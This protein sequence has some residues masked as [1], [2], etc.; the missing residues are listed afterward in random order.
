VSQEGRPLFLQTVQDLPQRTLS[1]LSG[2]A[3]LW[4][5]ACRLASGAHARPLLIVVAER[6]AVAP[7]EAALRLYLTALGSGLPVASLP[8]DDVRAWDGLSPH[9]DL[10]RQRLG[11]LELARRGAP[12]AILCSARGLIQRQ[13]SAEALQGLILELKAG[14]EPGRKGLLEALVRRGYTVREQA[15]EP[16]TVSLKGGVMDIWP[17]GPQGGPACPHRVLRRGDRGHPRAGPPQP[18]RTGSPPPP[19]PAPCARGRRG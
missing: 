8:A 12:A 13:L 19:A 10:P 16:G 3:A 7:A 18:P 6:E 1:G 2:S 14:D 5:L 9:P 17:I 15:P 11:A 4:W